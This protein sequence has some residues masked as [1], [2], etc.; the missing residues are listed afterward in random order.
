MKI[1]LW[2]LRNNVEVN[3]LEE[4]DEND[5]FILNNGRGKIDCFIV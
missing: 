1:P 3:T 4:L 2:H 5:T